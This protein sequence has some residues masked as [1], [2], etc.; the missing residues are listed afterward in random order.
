MKKILN[1]I[2]D[3][4]ILIHDDWYYHAMPFSL[5]KYANV[6][7]NGILSPYLLPNHN[8]SY[9]YIFVS[10]ANKESKYSA[11]A[12]YSIYPNFIING[13]IPAIKAEDSYIKKLIYGG[14]HGM[15]FTSL[16]DD[17]YQ[18]Y[19]KIRPED[20]VGIMFNLEKFINQYENKTN[21]SFNILND[22]VI[23]LNELESTLPILDYYSGKEINKQ[24]V[25]ALAKEKNYNK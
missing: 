3:K 18:V 2:E 8:S 1:Y 25:L 14:Y 7:K 6:L 11:F 4:D 9:R 21:H 5:D 15:S 20:I 12:N 16:Y 24:K 22:L 23:L 17:E 13:N 19:K 10:R